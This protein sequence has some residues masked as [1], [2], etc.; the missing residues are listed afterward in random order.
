MPW[1]AR[2]SATRCATA[3]TAAG[4]RARRTLDDAEAVPPTAQIMCRERL[5]WLDRLDGLPLSQTYP[6]MD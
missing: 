6:G 5:D 2:P 1:M 4:R 3:P